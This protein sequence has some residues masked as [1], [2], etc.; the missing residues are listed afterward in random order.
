MFGG[1][2]SSRDGRRFRQFGD[3]WRFD[4]EARRWDPPLEC[5]SADVSAPS[6]GSRDR[7]KRTAAA[8]EAATTAGPSAR[9]GHRMCC[10]QGGQLLVFGGFS[11]KK[12]NEAEYLSDVHSLDLSG[13]AL[14]RSSG[15]GAK[16]RGGGDRPSRR[17]AC[18][19][20]AAAGCDAA[21]VLGGVCPRKKKGGANEQLAVLEDLWRLEVAELQWQRIETSGEGPGPRTSMCHCALPPG[22]ASESTERRL[23]FG[24]ALLL[25]SGS[26]ATKT[27]ELSVFHNDVFILDLSEG[28]GQWSRL[29]SPFGSTAAPQRHLHVA[30]LALR[31]VD[32]GGVD[33][34]VL[35]LEASASASGKKGRNRRKA[36]GAPDCED[37]WEGSAPSM[38]RGR[39][40]ASCTVTDGHLWVFGGACESGTK[41][42]ITMDDLWRLP[43]D[44]ADSPRTTAESSWECILPASDKV[45]VWFSDSESDDEDDEEDFHGHSEELARRCEDDALFVP[46]MSK[47]QQ[48][49]EKKKQQAEAKRQ[50]QDV[51]GQARNDK[52][53]EKKERQRTQAKGAAGA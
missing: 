11:E 31:K 33:L 52:R 9:S 20:W 45:S 19:M 10:T 39:I 43:L 18:L 30:E 32:G 37:G 41:R 29:W 48:K 50:I 27:R 23:I 12:N 8:A 4:L 51:K 53:E 13:N 28:P 36:T 49:E 47:K 46:G 17:S 21:Y 40:A 6:A 14:W 3:L 7:G 35:A 44:T 42:E 38:P 5:G 2:W 25:S 15:R 34:G 22:P 1:E 26:K 16:G 24:G